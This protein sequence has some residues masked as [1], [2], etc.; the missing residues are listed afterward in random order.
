M[1]NQFAAW[2]MQ[3]A[4]FAAAAKR[5]NCENG[6]ARNAS[7]ASQVQHLTAAFSSCLL[8]LAVDSQSL[9][10]SLSFPGNESTASDIWSEVKR[11]CVAFL[12]FLCITTEKES[13]R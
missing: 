9:T 10:H 2:S 11:V 5:E 12:F 3:M 7:H 8:L 4:A 13:E 6:I 1:G